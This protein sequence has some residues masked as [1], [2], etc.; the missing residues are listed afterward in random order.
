MFSSSLFELIQLQSI[1]DL[2]VSL[3]SRSA[4]YSVKSVH[5][6]VLTEEAGEGT[7]QPTP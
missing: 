6:M 7:G 1:S 5:T 4:D 2:T 3:R